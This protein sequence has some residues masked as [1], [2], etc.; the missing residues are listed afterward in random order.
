[1]VTGQHSALGLVNRLTEPAASPP[2]S[3][4]DSE[5]TKEEEEPENAPVL[6]ML[7]KLGLVYVHPGKTNWTVF[8]CRAIN[9]EFEVL[10]PVQNGIQVTWNAHGPADEE[11]LLV[12]EKTHA[13]VREYQFLDSSYSFFIPS[14]RALSLDS[15][16]ISISRIPERSPRWMVVSIP[17]LS[18]EKHVISNMKAGQLAEDNQ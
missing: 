5:G 11:L 17:Y 16:K 9:A 18:N 4:D 14:D 1:M 2:P 15:A 10:D 6:E 12:K 13:E 3:A 8:I 7:Q